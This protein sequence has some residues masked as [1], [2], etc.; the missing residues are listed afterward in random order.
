[1]I[2]SCV[3]RTKRDP[4]SPIDVR[5]KNN[6]DYLLN[7]PEL[8]CSN[9]PCKVY[10]ELRFVFPEHSSA[11]LFHTIFLYPYN[12][13]LQRL[14]AVSK[15]PLAN[16][17]QQVVISLPFFTPRLRNRYL[18]GST[19]LPFHGA[20][21]KFWI[22][23]PRTLGM[24]LRRFSNLQTVV[25]LPSWDRRSDYVK[26]NAP[27]L[28]QIVSHSWSGYSSQFI[29]SRGLIECQEIER[30]ELWNLREV[31][32]ALRGVHD[33]LQHLYVFNLGT[34]WLTIISPSWKQSAY[35]QAFELPINP[36]AVVSLQFR[37]NTIPI[38]LRV[39]STAVH[40]LVWFL[41]IFDELK[42]LHLEAVS[43]RDCEEVSLFA[44]SLN[45]SLY[46]NLR[47]LTMKSLDLFPIDCVQLFKAV[48]EHGQISY[49]AIDGVHVCCDRSSAGK[50]FKFNTA[51]TASCTV[52]EV[53]KAYLQG[54]QVSLQE[55][56]YQW[57]SIF[58]NSGMFVSNVSR[59]STKVV[60]CT[61][62][63]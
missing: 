34:G 29:D 26:A 22:E 41:P 49:V 43:A 27:E 61:H 7:G 60:G 8:R 53:L 31:L 6:N 30:Y 38:T 2:S 15:S 20:L 40:D 28:Q 19:N 58:K 37:E 33:R 17:V 39:H 13:S 4:N 51:Q 23:I 46:P 56:E 44:T 54:G 57:I 14:T 52:E 24:L 21:L 5:R 32:H 59:K 42:W 18:Q 9:A 50:Y 47:T 1:M 25:I 55:L 10:K 11:V 35:R 48:R 16:H 63:A 36:R 3:T 45:P 12:R 62:F